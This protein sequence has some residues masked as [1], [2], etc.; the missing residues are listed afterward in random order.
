MTPTTNSP[1][2]R[3]R[4]LLRYAGFA[5]I[6]AVVTL[7]LLGVD[8]RRLAGEPLWLKPLK[9][10]VSSGIAALTVE[11]I[12]TRAGG[13]IGRINACRSVIAW[14]FA[15]EMAVICVQ[16]ARGVRSH[17]NL[18]TPIDTALFASMGLVI[19]VVVL[20]AAVAVFLATDRRS[21]WSP[22]ERVAARWGMA[23]FVAAA[24][25]G[26]LMARPTREQSLAASASGRPALVGSHFVGSVEGMTRTMPVTGWSLESGDLRVPHFLGMHAIQILM[27]MAF[28]MRR[29][30]V[31]MGA[32]ST[33]RRMALLGG[34]WGVVWCGAL[35]QALTGRSVVDP[36]GFGWLLWGSAGGVL[37]C[38]GSMLPLGVQRKEVGV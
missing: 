10:F 9:F 17:F 26:N 8:P 18:S 35:G 28:L 24:F 14:G 20:A 11:W 31:P 12:V 4:A 23:V 33:R 2:P 37:V 3:S 25:L 30:G 21:R 29:L 36:G 6:G 38:I 34:L 15:F 7:L 5:G 27:L 22:V 32:E 1:E 16:A 13:A 19:T